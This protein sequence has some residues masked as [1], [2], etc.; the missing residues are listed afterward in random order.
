MFEIFQKSFVES[1]GITFI[2]FAL[3]IV[4]ELL[5]LKFKNGIIRFTQKSKF[6]S[7]IVSSFFGSVPGCVGTF[8]MDSLFMAGLLGFGGIIA[9]MIAT[10]G[11]EAFLLISL[12]AKGEVSFTIFITLTLTLFL[13]GIFGGVLADFF[14]KKTKMKVAEKCAITKHGHEKFNLR[15]FLTAHI[16]QHIFKKHIW[17]IFLWI[18]VT[19]LA[20]EF[21]QTQFNLSNIFE[22]VEG[23]WILLAATLVGVIPLSGPNVV[24]VMLFANGFVP[25][26]VLLANSIVQDGH[27]LLPILGFSVSDAM[28]IKIFNLIFG[29]TIGMTLLFFGF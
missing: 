4:I 15:H 19:I 2:I 3:M 12:V 6:W 7:Y 21:L 5:V 14:A 8:A 13:L 1:A 10:S 23:I 16:W 27:G 22:N 24:L 26:S 28:K 20:I 9:A 18:F 11:D 25:F 17:H 29:F